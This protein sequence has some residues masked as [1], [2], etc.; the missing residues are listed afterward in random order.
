MLTLVMAIPG[1]NPLGAAV[2]AAGPT[3]IMQY[4]L[5]GGPIAALATTIPVVPG[6]DLKRANVFQ[7]PSQLVG[8]LVVTIIAVALA[9]L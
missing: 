4:F 3:A 8:L 1:I 6:S 9:G 2:A 5:T 7:R